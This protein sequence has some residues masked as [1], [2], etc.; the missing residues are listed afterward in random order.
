MCCP[1]FLWKAQ[2]DSKRR[3]VGSNSRDKGV[4]PKVTHKLRNSEFRRLAVTLNQLTSPPR[5]YDSPA[6]KGST[7]CARPKQTFFI[8]RHHTGPVEY[9]VEWLRLT[10]SIIITPGGAGSR[11]P[12]GAGTNTGPRDAR[13]AQTNLS[14]FPPPRTLSQTLSHFASHLAFGDVGSRRRHPCSQGALPAQCKPLGCR[15]ARVRVCVPG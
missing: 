14:N 7:S 6:A 8:N 13:I 10:C 4:T 5:R 12:R 3:P 1:I 11:T 9:S 2:R 15:S